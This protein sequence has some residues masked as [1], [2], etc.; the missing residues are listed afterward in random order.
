MTTDTITIPENV[1]DFRRESLTI[2]IGLGA[3]QALVDK[4]AKAMRL[5]RKD[6]IVLPAGR[7][8]SLSRGKGWARCGRGDSAQWGERETGGYRVGVGSW[9]VFSSDGFHRESRT[10]WVVKHIQVGNQ[11]WTLAD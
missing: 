5:S 7:Y 2:A 6:T 9:L 10:E 8:E 11:T 4:L 1:T 3:D